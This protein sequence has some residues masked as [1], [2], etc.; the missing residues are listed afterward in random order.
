MIVRTV[1][2]DIAPEGLGATMMHEHLIIDSPLIEDRWPHIHLSSV[3]D[4]V[5]ELDA[6]RRAGA[7][8]LVDTMPCAGGRDPLRLAE[9]SRRSG[10]HL[11]AITGLHT[12]KYYGG[13][14]WALEAPV[15]VMAGLFAADITEGIDRYDYTGPVVERTPHRAGIIKVA[16]LGE[17]PDD[18]ERRVFAAAALAHRRTG[19]PIL[20]HCEEGRGALEQVALL[21]EL[22]V[23][24]YRVVISHTDKVR[25]L[26]YHRDMLDSG[27]LVVYDQALRQPP[28]EEKGT[29]WIVGEMIEAGYVGQLTL[30]TDGAR[31]SLWTSLGGSPGLAWLVGG[32]VEVLRRRGVD[33]QAIDKMLVENPARFLSFEEAA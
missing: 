15:E 32:F 25:D 29:A 11:L 23:A 7:G 17:A 22:G 16:T 1:L 19:A 26:G 24:L 4:A 27:V 31:R 12:A 8:T 21:S 14:R 33:P 9:A 10:V 6:C 20:T 28:D 18:R 13:H 30:G 3:D 5:S 2:G